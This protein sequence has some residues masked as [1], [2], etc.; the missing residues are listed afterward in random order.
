MPTKSE[1]LLSDLRKH[2]RAGRCGQCVRQGTGGGRR[3]RHLRGSASRGTLRRALRRWVLRRAWQTPWFPVSHEIQAVSSLTCRRWPSPPSHSPH[4]FGVAAGLPLAPGRPRSCDGI[5]GEY[6][7]AVLLTHALAHL[8][9]VLSGGTLVSLVLG[10]CMHSATTIFR[11]LRSSSSAV[12]SSLKAAC[13]HVPACPCCTGAF[14]S[15]TAHSSCHC[16]H[17][18]PGTSMLHRYVCSCTAHIWSRCMR[19][20]GVPGARQAAGGGGRRRG[21]AAPGGTGGPARPGRAAD[22]QP[23]HHLLPGRHLHR[24]RRCAGA[25]LPVRLRVP[26]RAGAAGHRTWHPSTLTCL[27]AISIRAPT[28]LAPFKDGGLVGQPYH[29]IYSATLWG[30]RAGRL[31]A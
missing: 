26:R 31:Q 17:T 22:H 1:T 4:A 15:C 30:V 27:R 9:Y 2:E 28:A 6:R 19:R 5:R 8:T 12:C 25:G 14:C 23:H 3:E 11:K 24:E 21:R 18:R 16:M 7:R 20:R 29:V 13:T 10:T